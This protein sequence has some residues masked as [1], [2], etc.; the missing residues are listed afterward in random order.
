MCV[1]GFCQKLEQEEE[2]LSSLH[3]Y[4]TSIVLT[5]WT[6]VLLETSIVFFLIFLKAHLLF[7]YPGIWLP[8][9]FV[10]LRLCVKQAVGLTCK[11]AQGGD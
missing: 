10:A 4:L 3:F 1:S 6:D 5:L 8:S 11:S 7:E 9:L 2:S